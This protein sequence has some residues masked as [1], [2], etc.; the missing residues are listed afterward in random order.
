MN[1][2]V[3]VDKNWAIGNNGKLLEHIK[4]DL[5]NFKNKTT[6]KVIVVGRETLGTFPSGKPL[7]NRINIVLSRDLN[8]NIEDGIAAHSIEELLELIKDYSIEDVFVVGGSSIYQQLLPYVNTAYVTKFSNEHT[9]D[10]YFPNLDNM[11]EWVHE[12]SS[13]LFEENGIKYSFNVY[14]RKEQ[15]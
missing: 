13:E 5:I 10:R 12:S 2:L 4:G 7:A 14:K 9:A 8:F 6:G 11:L 1:L 15:V 3:A